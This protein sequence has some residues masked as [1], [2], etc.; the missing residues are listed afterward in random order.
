MILGGY[1]TMEIRRCNNLYQE[2]KRRKMQML[3][4]KIRV[5]CPEEV[6]VAAF[7]MVISHNP[8][9]QLN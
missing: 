3:L 4:L 5:I 6:F 8:E 9:R 1:L 7:G 2:E